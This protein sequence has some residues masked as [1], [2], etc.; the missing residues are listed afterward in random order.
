MVYLVYFL[1][2]SFEKID[3]FLG[4]PP[5]RPSTSSA[6]LSNEFM[7][8]KSATVVLSSAS[9]QQLPF[10]SCSSNDA[11]EAIRIN[12]NNNSNRKVPTSVS[13]LRSSASASSLTTTEDKHCARYQ[14]EVCGG[15]GL[16]EDLIRCKICL[17]SDDCNAAASL[18][19]HITCAPLADIAFERRGIFANIKDDGAAV[20]NDSRQYV[21]AVCSFHN[22]GHGSF[23]K[24]E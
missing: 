23:L 12:N 19:Y 2:G 9:S 11:K 21:I 3:E 16:S 1:I 15:L 6:T 5:Q 22:S 18:R 14:C 13:S 7:D 17:V 10:S 20:E 24:V 4:A 8:Q